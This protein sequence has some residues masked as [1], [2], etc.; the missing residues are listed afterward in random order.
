MFQSRYRED[1]PENAS[2][3][4]FHRASFLR[5]SPG[6]SGEKERKAG[7]PLAMEVFFHGKKVEGCPI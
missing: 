4:V 5:N 6:K 3:M 2:S 1:S 7:F